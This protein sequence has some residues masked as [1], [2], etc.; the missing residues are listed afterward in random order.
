MVYT[1]TSLALA[2]VELFV[3]L[4]PTVA[5]D[6]LVFTSA[7]I[8]TDKVEVARIDM[9]DLPPDWENTDH[10]LLQEMG[11]RWVTGQKS[12]A[13]EVPSIAVKGEWNVLLNPLHPDFSK[14]SVDPPKV[15]AFDQRMFGR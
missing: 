12:V 7:F 14:I 10:P 13:L 11:S 15:W 8:P 3:H 5:P 4:D 6:D 9:G 2:A 1:S